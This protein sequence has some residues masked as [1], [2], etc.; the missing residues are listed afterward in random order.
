M[1]IK[2][3]INV[4]TII[5][6]GLITNIAV[7]QTQDNLDTVQAGTYDMGKMWT[8]DYPPISYFGQTYHFTPDAKWFEHARLSSLRFANFCSASFVSGNGLVMTNHHCAR[9][10]GFSVQKPGEDFN[11]NGFYAPN[12]ADERRVS[13]LYV[14]QLIKVE[15]ITVRVQK[16]MAEAGNSSNQIEA[17]T[18]EF[19]KITNEYKAKDDWKQLEIQPVT[20]YS[21]GK[22][23]LYGFKRYKDVRLVFMPELNLGFYGGDYDNFTYPR[24]AL[25]CSFFR[26]Y[27]DNGKPLK[28]DHFF[29]FTKQPVQENDPVFVVGNPGSTGRLWTISDLEYRRDVYL[30]ALVRYLK[31]R[32]SILQQYNKAVKSD[33]I[34]NEIFG[35]ENSIKALSGEL[36]GL[37]NPYLIARKTAF[38]K[39]FKA[40]AQS[41][42]SLSG[43]LPIWNEIEKTN[44]E[45]KKMFSENFFFSGNPGLT[46]NTLSLAMLSQQYI[47]LLKAGDKRAGGILKRL[48]L[49]NRNPV[50][51]LE[52]SYLATF[53]T[54][55]RNVF[56]ETDPFVQSALQGK[57]PKDAAHTLLQNTV[58]KEEE[59]WNKLVKADT[60][61]INQSTDALI[62]LAKQAVTRYLVVSP[63]F[64]LSTETL[65]ASRSELGRAL[66]ELYGTQIPPD[67]TM[68]LRIAD[69]I[70]KGYEYNGTLAPPKTSFFGLYDRFFSFNKQY[71]W[72]LPK[73]WQN[74]PME[75][76]SLPMNFVSTA[77]ITGGNSGSPIINKNLEVVGLV[78]D[79]N[80]ESLPGRFI[81]VPEANRAVSVDVTGIMGALKYIYKAKRLEKELQGR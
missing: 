81:Y 40:D 75:L 59:S 26:V 41:K 74:P 34:L 58:L 9:D 60:M 29:K 14:D 37:N 12:N 27:D 51:V 20:L 62:L 16:A 8:F 49:T 50:A 30:P 52:E 65:M 79:G 17:R 24:Y 70:V 28:T 63:K 45:L 61:F 80:I 44:S 73:R 1:K 66:F 76:L 69:G 68:S 78:F 6:L 46:G 64:R 11:N 53:L 72:L 18:K 77:D 3:F 71:P 22:Y 35:M 5:L 48:Q 33:S 67:A 25:D 31:N 56:G 23:S 57:S 43:Y 21:G 2:A 42:S 7:A 19:E 36:V 10:A 15:D 47:Q 13:W 54:E 55:A 4:G 39:K 38:E 32:S